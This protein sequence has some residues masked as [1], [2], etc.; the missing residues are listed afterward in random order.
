MQAQFRYAPRW[1]GIALLVVASL[2]TIGFLYSSIEGGVRWKELLAGGPVFVLMFYGAL[3]FAL[4]C[5]Y[6]TISPGGVSVRHRPLWPGFQNW[7]LDRSQIALA[8]WR[9]VLV[10]RSQGGYVAG[11]ETHEG[12]WKDLMGPYDRPEDAQ[13]MAQELAHIW[14]THAVERAGRPRKLDWAHAR[15]VIAWGGAF[16]LALINGALVEIFY[17]AR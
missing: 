1:A 15:T 2:G 4:N 17:T 9:Y 5:R 6:L 14:N 3:L 10:S 16:I 8:H 12:I 13:Q 11:A 7:S